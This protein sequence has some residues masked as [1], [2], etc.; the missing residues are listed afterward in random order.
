[1]N[2]T[3]NATTVSRSGAICNYVANVGGVP[4]PRFIA[5]I[6]PIQA[7]SGDPS[8]SNPRAISGVSEVNPHNNGS[9]I[10]QW[11]ELWELGSFNA[12]GQPIASTTLIRSKNYVR[13]SSS[14]DYYV[15]SPV[16]CVIY[17]YDAQKTFISSM[18][19]SDT[20]IT[21]PAQAKWL[22]F[23]MASSYGT[24]YNN[25]VSINNP[26]TDTAYHA[27]TGQ[28]ATIDLG[29]TVY[30]GSL[31]VG[32]GLLTITHVDVDLGSVTWNYENDYAYFYHNFT[33]AKQIDTTGILPNMLCEIYKVIATTNQNGWKN[34]SNNSIGFRTQR[35][36]MCVKDTSYTDPTTFQNAV[37]GNKVIYE[38]A[39]PQ[40][41]QLTPAQVTQIL[42]NNVW[43]DSGDSEVDFFKIIRT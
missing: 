9:S 20:T 27:Y 16:D 41:Y 19:R 5:N 6:T 43:A 13:I 1:M 26:A 24:T 35:T 22:R 39:T 3:Y 11:D 25:D 4:L 2:G 12:S 40:T 33:D 29:Q 38:L 15:K 30:G 21:T 32:T 36:H 10:N 7:G 34:A 23:R 8:P 42:E 14:T 17:Y 18:S 28:T 37:S 31:N